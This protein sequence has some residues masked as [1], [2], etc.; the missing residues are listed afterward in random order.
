MLQDDDFDNPACS[1]S[2]RVRTLVDRR[3]R[4]GQVV[5]RLPWRCDHEH[6]GRQGFLSEVGTTGKKPNAVEQQINYC[7]E[8][9]MGAET[10]EVGIGA[11]ALDVRFHEPPVPRHAGCGEIDGPVAKYFK[12]GEEHLQ[13]TPWSARPVLQANCHADNYG[14][15]IRANTLSE[16]QINGFPT[17]RLK[18]QKPGSVHRRFSG[19]NKMVRATPYKRGSD[20]YV[21]LEVYVKWRGRGLPVETPAVRN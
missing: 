20:E 8:N 15:I 19:C 17:Y 18:W 2:M 1:G 7:R 4:G 12:I 9:R 13:W 3:W 6:E 5:R 10:M 14:G 11:N 16:G 21:G